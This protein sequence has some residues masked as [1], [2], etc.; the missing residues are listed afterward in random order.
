[1]YNCNGVEQICLE[2]SSNFKYYF[3][4][5]IEEIFDLGHSLHSQK[6]GT[7]VQKFDLIHTMSLPFICVNM[8]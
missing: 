2:M 3:A 5:V 1:M 7:V 4:F 8:F 6:M